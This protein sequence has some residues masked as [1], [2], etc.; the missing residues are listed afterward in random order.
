[1]VFDTCNLDQFLVGGF[2]PSAK[3]Y[4]LLVSYEALKNMKVN[5][6][7]YSQ[8]MENKSHVPNLQLDLVLWIYRKLYPV[9]PKISARLASNL[10][11]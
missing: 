8:Y 7:Y 5:W 11:A 6:D 10:A 1:M 9:Q 4:T 3:Y 2:S